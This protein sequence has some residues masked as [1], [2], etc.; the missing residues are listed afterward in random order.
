LRTVT[1]DGWYKVGHNWKYYK[2]TVTS[3]ATCEVVNGEVRTTYQYTVKRFSGPGISHF[4]VVVPQC[5]NQSDIIS[6]DPNYSSFGQDG[7]CKNCSVWSN[8]IKWEWKK[9]WGDEQTFTITIKGQSTGEG[10][11]IV[12]TSH[13]FSDTNTCDEGCLLFQGV[14]APACE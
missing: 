5:V 9:S 12:K 6:S 14:C 3:S 7:S 1:K 8:V 10:Y 4:D 11:A 13:N 2:Y